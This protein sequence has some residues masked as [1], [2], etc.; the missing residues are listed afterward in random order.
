[1]VHLEI[2]FTEYYKKIIIE[3]LKNICNY[4]YFLQLLQF[5]KMSSF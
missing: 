4:N 5:F 1:M 2:D 3:K